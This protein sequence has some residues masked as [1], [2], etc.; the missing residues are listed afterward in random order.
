MSEVKLWAAIDVKSAD[1]RMFEI[2]GIFDTES[3]A[4]AACIEMNHS[5][6]SMAL[7]RNYGYESV[8]APDV[9]YPRFEDQQ[10]AQEPSA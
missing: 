3:Q 10:R 2:I 9:R 8:V 5:Y 1:G 4:D 7:N 6:F